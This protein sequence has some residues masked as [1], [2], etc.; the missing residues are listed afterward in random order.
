M[1]NVVVGVDGSGPSRA[2]LHRAVAEAHHRGGTLEAV[3]VYSPSAADIA[4]DPGALLESRGSAGQG[5]RD[6]HARSAA[7]ARLADVVGEELGA[8]A[9]TVH[10]T[11]IADHD[12]AEALAERARDAD[13]LVIGLRRRSRVGKFILGST[14][15]S[16]ILAARCPVLTVGADWA[17]ASDSSGG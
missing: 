17:S 5:V 1:P 3:H 8:S 7:L 10:L 13:M 4:E 2:A 12:V 16:A 14:A 6:E 15:Q 9:T 11:V